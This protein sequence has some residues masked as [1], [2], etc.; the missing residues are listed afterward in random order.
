MISLTFLHGDFFADQWEGLSDETVAT[1]RKEVRGSKHMLAFPFSFR[2]AF[3]LEI[4]VHCGDAN[5]LLATTA[6]FTQDAEQMHL[7]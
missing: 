7:C 2:A 1:D 3:S 4:C 6:L 5:F